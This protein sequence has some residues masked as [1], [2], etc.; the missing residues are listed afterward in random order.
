[1]GGKARAKKILKSNWLTLATLTGVIVGVILGASLRTRE[2]P[3][4]Q[5]EAMYVKFI[6]SLFLQ[7]LK[8]IIIPL[9]IPSLIGKIQIHNLDQISNDHCFQ[10]PLEPWT[11][12][13][14]AKLEL[15]V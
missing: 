3:Y 15:E 4:S 2:E 10:S 5:R 12:H 1:M 8:A 9:V 7:M 13:L 11:Y 6:G 14:V